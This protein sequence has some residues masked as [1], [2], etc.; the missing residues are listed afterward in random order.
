[1]LACV[2]TE[3]PDVKPKKI[4][5][6][7]STKAVKVEESE[8][9]IKTKD[10]VVRDNVWP[11]QAIEFDEHVRTPGRTIVSMTNHMIYCLRIKYCSRHFDAWAGVTSIGPLLALRY[12]SATSTPT[13]TAI[14]CSLELIRYAERLTEIFSPSASRRTCIGL[15][16]QGYIQICQIRATK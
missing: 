2:H 6:G 9:L 8:L 5:Q 13:L 1:M 7:N 4:W 16:K 15:P 12:P 10:M 14:M 3:R 11:Q